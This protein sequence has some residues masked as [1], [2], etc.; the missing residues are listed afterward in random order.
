[1]TATTEILADLAAQRTAVGLDTLNEQAAML[2]RVDRKY[3]VSRDQV[4]L[5]LARLPR[6]TRALEIEG[7]RTFGYES[8][9]FDTKDLITYRAHLQKRRRRYKVRY[10]CYL[11]SGSEFLEVKY[12]GARGVTQKARQSM[13]VLQPSSARNRLDGAAREFVSQVVDQAY[14]LRVPDGL[15]PAVT[16]RHQ[17][18]TF[19][20]PDASRFTVDVDLGFGDLHRSARLRDEYAIVES[21]SI[22]GGAVVDRLL[23][24]LRI[25]PLSVSKYCLAVAALRPDLASNPWHR[26]LKQHV[27]LSPPATLA[28]PRV[29]PDTRPHARLA[30]SDSLAVL[31]TV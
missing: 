8:T 19:L 21:K 29:R 24:D 5:L 31:H 23:K 11:D 14:G 3:V 2:T 20:S 18:A 1:M 22:D 4:A 15:V 7:R 16:T 13:V 30:V 9:Y 26:L 27:E 12:K 17:R 28:R 6:E 10:R 25:R